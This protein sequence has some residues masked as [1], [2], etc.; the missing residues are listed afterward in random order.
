M[1][2][3]PRESILGPLMGSLVDRVAVLYEAIRRD[4]LGQ[5]H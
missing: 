2:L 3:E 5:V 4:T 1:R